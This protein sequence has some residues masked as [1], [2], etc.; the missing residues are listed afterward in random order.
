MLE[1]SFDQGE[2]TDYD[3]EMAASSRPSCCIYC[4]PAQFLPSDAL[5]EDSEVDEDEDL[6]THSDSE[7]ESN[8]DHQIMSLR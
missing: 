8:V 6:L 7:H 3:E 5:H 4:K 2:D 1:I